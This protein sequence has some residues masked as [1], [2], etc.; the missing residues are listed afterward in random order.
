MSAAAFIIR[1]HVIAAALF[2]SACS[3]G[4][5]PD[6]SAA[7]APAI[8]PLSQRINEKNGYQVDSEGNWKPVNNRRSEF[9]SRGNATAFDKQVGKKTYQTRTLE[10]K[11]WWGNQSYQTQ[12]YQGKTDGS[13]FQQP[14]SEAG[15]SAREAGRD[16]GLQRPYATNTYTTHA[17]REASSQRLS[18]P[19]DA[20][21]QERRETFTPPEIIDW[22]EQRQMDI[23][24]SK[25]I[26]G[27]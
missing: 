18:R 13:R 1:P 10:R 12:S 7:T 16:A 19:A 4:D 5:G 11:S 15:Q 17:A 9:E 26:L 21:T 2:C 22:Q 23:Q 25:S 8:K 3:L 27:R 14:F 20:E 24:Q 6:K